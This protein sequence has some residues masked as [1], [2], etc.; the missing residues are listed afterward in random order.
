ME[1]LKILHIE[2]PNYPNN[3]LAIRVFSAVLAYEQF[4]YTISHNDSAGLFSQIFSVVRICQ[5][6]KNEVGKLLLS[7]FVAALDIRIRCQQPHRSV[8]P[9]AREKTSLSLRIKP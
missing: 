2:T 8:Q 3:D 7:F 1:K 9:Q 4:R 6:K 5:V